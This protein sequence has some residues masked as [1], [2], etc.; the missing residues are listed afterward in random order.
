MQTGLPP[1]GRWRLMAE[2]RRDPRAASRQLIWGQLH[3]SGSGHQVLCPLHST[4][5]GSAARQDKAPLPLQL[6]VEPSSH[7]T[8]AEQGQG[9]HDFVPLALPQH[10]PSSPEAQ[11]ESLAEHEPPS[12]VTDVPSQQSA[13]HVPWALGPST[14]ESWAVGAE[15][16]QLSILA[17]GNWVNDGSTHGRAASSEAA[18][19]AAATASATSSAIFLKRDIPGPPLFQLTG[20]HH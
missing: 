16:S 9:G 15:R 1:S 3:G 10:E 4:K 14:A 20:Y 18:A 2:G 6:T 8:S 17:G 13:V 12:H 11:A 19:G 7:V 5:Q